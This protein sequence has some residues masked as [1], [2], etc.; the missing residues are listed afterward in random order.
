MVLMSET[1]RQVVLLELT[2]PWEYWMEEAIER[3]RAK[4]EELAGECQSKGWKTRC[5]PIEVGCRG[6]IGQSLVRAL[7][8]LGVRGQPSRRAIKNSSDTAEKASRWLW[9]RRE[10]QL[11]PRHKPGLDHP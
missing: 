1:R 6:F 4:Y 5:N 11:L 2:L 7:K 3:K 10:P 9:I 8:M